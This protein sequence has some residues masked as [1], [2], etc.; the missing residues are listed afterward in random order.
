MALPWTYGKIPTAEEWNA[1][2]SL[3]WS[4]SGAGLI[5]RSTDVGETEEAPVSDAGLTLI[6]GDYPKMPSSTVSGL[7]SA[8]SVGDGSF[9]LV[10]DNT[11]T[12][13][14]AALVGGGSDIVVAVTIG[15]AW[16][17]WV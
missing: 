15:G 12:T 8:A 16:V 1:L 2:L 6:G 3:I 10:T 11:G 14:R 7:P 5:Q 9:A 13:A 4:P 17:V